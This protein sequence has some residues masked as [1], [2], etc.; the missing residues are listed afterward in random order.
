MSRCVNIATMKKSPPS[1]LSKHYSHVGTRRKTLSKCGVNAFLMPGGTPAKGN[2]PSFPI[3]DK[4]CC[5][6]CG[7]ARMAYTRIGASLNIPDYPETYKRKLRAA[8]KKLINEALLYSDKRDKKNQ[9]NWAV[10]ASR[11]YKVR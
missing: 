3:V 6:H 5:F 7:L 4:N 8:R 10:A 2:V 11:R 1:R 9:C